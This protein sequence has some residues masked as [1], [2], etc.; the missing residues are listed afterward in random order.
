MNPNYQ[1]EATTT[2]TLTI[3]ARPVTFTATSEERE[4]T[5]ATITID[6]LT[7]STGENEGLVSGHT[8]NVSF[9]ASGIEAGE[10]TGTITSVEDVV[11]MSGET[12]VTSN[13]AIT[14]ENGTLTITQT[15][16]EFTIALDDDSYVYDGGAHYNANTA[17]STAATGTTTYSYS[18]TETGEYVSDLTTLTKTDVGVYTI[19][20]KGVN[21][22]YQAEATTTA[23]LTITPRS[24]TLTSAT[25]EKVYDGTPLTNDEVTVGG[26]GFAEGEG[27][28][29]DVT[30]TIT[31]MGTVPNAFTYT[32]NANTLAD[33]YNITTVEGTLKITPVT[34]EVVVTIVGK[35]HTDQYDGEMHTITGY[36]IVSISNDLYT[37]ADFN[38]PA[39]DATVATAARMNV[40]TTEMT[41]SEDDFDNISENF[42]NVNFNVTPGYQTITPI[43]TEIVITAESDSKIYDGTP[44]TNDGYTY[45]E[46][47]LVDGDVLTAVVEGTIT[48]VGIAE[49]LVTSYKVMRGETDVTMNY[50]FGESIDGELKV[51][52]RNVTLTS[53][54]DSKTYDGTPLTNSTVTVG[55]DGFAEGEG[56]TYNVTGSQTHA[57]FSDNTFTYTLNEGTQADN[58]NI[59]TV[60]GTLTI[61]KRPLTITLTASKHYDGEKLELEYDVFNSVTPYVTPDGVTVDVATLVTLAEGDYLASGH[62]ETEAAEQDVYV[63][64]QG[65]FNYVMQMAALQSNFVIKNGEENVNGNYDP[66]FNITLTILEPDASIDCAA[67]NIILP[68]GQPYATI[69]DVQQP[70]LIGGTGDIN[71]YVLT[72]N[73]AEGTPLAMGV[74]HITWTLSTPEG[75][76]LATCEQTVTVNYSQC[77]GV[78][79]YDGYNYGA[80]RIGSQCWL[81]ENL[82]NT[83]D[84][85]GNPI[86]GSPLFDD[87]A[88]IEKFGL[89]YTWYT[90]VGVAEGEQPAE[91]NVQGICPTGWHVPSH[92]DIMVLKSYVD[93]TVRNLRDLDPMHQY[94]IDGAQGVEPNY[95]FQSRGSGRYNSTTGRYEE[96]LTREFYWESTSNPGS[97]VIEVAGVTYFCDD[98]MLENSSRNDKRSVRCLRDE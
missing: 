61:S 88:N 49:N 10:Y 14:V 21:P 89:L 57:G 44:L 26:D 96:H 78:D 45:T 4:Y 39:Q 3:T 23:T 47:V 79:N 80:V 9:S 73:V 41:L 63:C 2:A 48:N 77:L 11:I 85:F 59:E 22:N 76:E 37:E 19:Y 5:G 35:N 56:A 24:V 92:A 28:T 25:D 86:E 31:D 72:P 29:Y 60:Y 15:D 27:A 93:G 90:A 8:H 97:T 83:V 98:I 70:A 62:V 95:G 75:A 84:A 34:A 20:V 13:Y 42:S 18:F 64:T 33:N 71:D 50:T 91:G 1:A 36:D 65:N 17:S 6:G 55:G 53:A 81:T 12:D 40:G 74:N 51:T 58:Y 30:G 66:S 43:E 69:A 52:P 32:L 7:L 38:K 54:T 46:G 87:E 94:W 82:H 16:E 67:D 68:D